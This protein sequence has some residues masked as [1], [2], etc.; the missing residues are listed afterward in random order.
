MLKLSRYLLI[1]SIGL[2]TACGQSFIVETKLDIPQPVSTQLP[3]RMAV[4]YDHELREFVYTENNE[5]RMN[6]AIS[7]GPS[8]IQ[9]FD[10]ILPAMFT[11]INRIEDLSNAEEQNYDAII[12]PEIKDIQFALPYETRSKVHETWIKYAIHV[13]QPDGVEITTMN[14]IGYGKSPNKTSIQFLLDEK[15]G[16]LYATNQAFRDVAANIII[17]FQSNPDIQQWLA[18]KPVH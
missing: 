17:S 2:V 18:T 6:W 11:T 5:D 8:Q 16:L 9:L 12:I 13:Q 15:K 1:L 3:L 4:F 7:I 14:V 10:L